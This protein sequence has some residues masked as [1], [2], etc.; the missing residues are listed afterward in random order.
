MSATREHRV[1]LRLAALLRAIVA[2]SAGLLVG[3]AFA[4][5]MPGPSDVPTRLSGLRLPFITNTGQ[6]DTD[7]AY[8]AP[9]AGATVFVTQRGELVYNFPAQRR[10]HL[11]HCDRIRTI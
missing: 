2:L 9:T 1:G 7:V 8:Y 3:P 10:R 6:V 11:W 4:G 5:T